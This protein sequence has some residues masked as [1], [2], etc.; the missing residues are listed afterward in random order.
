MFDQVELVPLDVPE[1][2]VFR[3]L[4]AKVGPLIQTQ[5]GE[6]EPAMLRTPDG[7]RCI[8]GEGILRQIRGMNPGDLPATVRIVRKATKGGTQ[9][10]LLEK[11]GSRQ[12][13]PQTSPTNDTDDIPF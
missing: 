7:W 8:F 3:V 11:E 9:V 4:E 1:G 6:A 5:Y 13:T 12:H 10:K 2:Q